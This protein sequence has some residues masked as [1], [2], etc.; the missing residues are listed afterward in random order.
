MPEDDVLTRLYDAAMETPEPRMEH[1]S[2]E[3]MVNVDGLGKRYNRS[4][5]INACKRRARASRAGATQFHSVDNW[6]K[7]I[8]RKLPPRDATSPQGTLLPV[9]NPH[10]GKLASPKSSP[11]DSSSGALVPFGDRDANTNARSTT[12]NRLM[13]HK[14]ASRKLFRAAPYLEENALHTQRLL[15][16]E[17]T[18][19][20][21]WDFA[22]VG[23]KV[24][25][26]MMQVFGVTAHLPS[27][28]QLRTAM[29]CF[30]LAK[31]TQTLG[32]LRSVFNV[33][34]TELFGAVY[35]DIDIDLTKNFRSPNE[36]NPP[37][38][39]DKDKGNKDDPAADAPDPPPA[40]EAQLPCF[41]SL[42]SYPQ[43]VLQ[44][45]REVAALKATNAQ[46][47]AQLDSGSVSL[48]RTQQDTLVRLAS[49]NA[50]HKRHLLICYFHSWRKVILGDEV[51]DNNMMKVVA[52]AN[53]KVILGRSFRQW[54]VGVRMLKKIENRRTM[55]RLGV[56]I[57]E[58]D[59][60]RATQD[61]KES[62][63]EEVRE[64]LVLPSEKGGANENSEKEKEKE[65]EKE[66]DRTKRVDLA[67]DY[68]VISLA[69]LYQ[70]MNFE[71]VKIEKV[72][73]T[74]VQTVHLASDLRTV[75]AISLI[76]SR[77]V[78][79]PR[80]VQ[81][82]VTAKPQQRAEVVFRALTTTESFGC[83]VTPDL[84]LQGGDHY[85]YIF[86]LELFRLWATSPAL[87]T[88]LLY[89]L[90]GFDPDV[91]DL[92][93][94]LSR[95]V[96]DS[97]TKESCHAFRYTYELRTW[98]EYRPLIASPCLKERLN[99]LWEDLQETFHKIADCSQRLSTTAFCNL[100]IN[101]GVIPESLTLEAAHIA[102]GK[103]HLMSKGG[104]SGL[105][106]RRTSL[107]LIEFSHALSILRLWVEADERSDNMVWII[108]Y[109]KCHI[110]SLFLN[111]TF[112]R[113]K[114]GKK[115]Y[116]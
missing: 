83:Y 32:P 34:L 67:R 70:W 4:D 20:S 27:P 57:A 21:G 13:E 107:N 10:Q 72:T 95:I 113:Q 98:E 6:N 65:K 46:L 76:V 55:Q 51:E 111:S 49:E 22:S 86:C 9:L 44:L 112:L 63:D 116:S 42:T 53:N 74:D 36:P 66:E 90:V 73:K 69:F 96:Y 115:K 93:D 105:K 17:W 59:D 30:L 29:C 18:S 75:E 28:S 80:S 106:A 85:L 37:G 16:A 50:E 2:K 14:A 114:M 62:S 3:F 68:S 45:E 35:C 104:K 58:D 87:D 48:S 100:L 11:L 31:L 8:R 78:K 88:N 77:A 97:A 15:Y 81:Y 94:V 108:F 56:Q 103:A 109:L 101:T 52:A 40:A 1:P 25:M 99:D 24:E 110:W 79:L 38:P 7:R 26:A 60:F 54:H 39:K 23:V 12:H 89:H 84:L 43:R 82:L 41:V 5:V 102:F 61:D 33:L 91:P 19:Q 71:L 47:Q 92:L 64:G